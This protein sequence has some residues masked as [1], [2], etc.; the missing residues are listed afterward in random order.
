ML[1]TI[2]S[3]WGVLY[4]VSIVLLL[5]YLSII[6][7]YLLDVAKLLRLSE[8]EY[9][10]LTHIPLDVHQVVKL[11][12]HNPLISA[13]IIIY[14]GFL[15]DKFYCRFFENK[16]RYV[17]YASV[18]TVVAMFIASDHGWSLTIFICTHLLS[19]VSMHVMY[20]ELVDVC[21]LM[22]R[23]RNALQKFAGTIQERKG[24]KSTR[25]MLLPGLL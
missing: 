19:L 18:S 10:L 8:V 14:Y 17:I 13:F 4:L 23:K 6:T 5:F 21:R 20:I 11:I 12:F 1:R 15:L 2:K 16:I 9:Y 22:A 24:Q 7:V 3:C 25:Q